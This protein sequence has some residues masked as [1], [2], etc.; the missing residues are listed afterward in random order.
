[1]DII[2]GDIMIGLVVA[3]GKNGEIGLNGGLPWGKTYWEDEEWYFNLTQ[4]E[5]RV[6]CRK[7]FLSTTDGRPF[8]VVSSD[9]TPVPHSLGN[10]NWRTQD[11]PSILHDVQ[12][13]HPNRDV[14]VI[15]GRAW[16][17]SAAPFVER[18]YI[19]RIDRSFACDVTVDVDLILNG[20]TCIERRQGEQTDL[21]FETYT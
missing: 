1:M 10:Y 17:H 14:F 12:K 18:I 6:G 11:P 5:I 13:R 21:C 8:Y 9:P 2:V 3:V 4:K 7:A 19:T 15:G 16:Y 20:R